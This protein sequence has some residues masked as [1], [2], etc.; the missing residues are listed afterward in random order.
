MG[1]GKKKKC[2][3]E[4]ILNVVGAGQFVLRLIRKK[5]PWAFGGL[6]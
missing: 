3:P 4:G 6:E 5:P 2:G 1:G